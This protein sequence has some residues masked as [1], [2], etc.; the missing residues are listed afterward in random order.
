VSE[1]DVASGLVRRTDSIVARAILRCAAPMIAP[2]TRV[3]MTRHIILFKALVL[4]AL[5]FATRPAVPYSVQTHESLIDLAWKQSIRPFLLQ[6]FPALTEL[7]IQ[8]AH[9]YA[10]G[11]CNIQDFGYYP[12]A[13]DFFSDL[14]HY[15]RSGDFVLSLL[16]NAQTPDE[17]AFAI[18]ALSHY[19]G[20]SIGHDDAVNQSVA[21]EF[22][23][24]EKEYG[25]LVNYAQNP[26]AHVQVEFAF[27]INQLSK[28][29][30][31]PSDYLEHVGLKI[32][33]RVL[34]RAFFETYGLNLPGLIGTRDVALRTYRF[35]VRSFLPAIA[36]AE[37]ILHKFPPEIPS[38]AGDQ[39]TKALRQAEAENGWEQYR[40]NA[41]IGS[42]ALAGLIF[43]LPKVGTLALLKIRGPNPQTEDL[44]INSVNRSIA[45][46]R[47]VLANFGSISTYVPNR[48]LDTGK[49]VKPGGYKLTD[50]TYAKLLSELTKHPNRPI[51]R[52]LKQDLTE[53]YA[54]PLAP[55]T[56][57]EDS[58]KWAKVQANLRILQSMPTVGD[59]NAVATQF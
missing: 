22:P 20:D 32:P 8:E 26:H 35:A 36:R 24:L 45:A 37:T 33:A 15:V 40:K 13:N 2:S 58:K 42:H 49:K 51:P 21:I 27:D 19:I 10:Y 6:R 46:L 47:L 7:Q 11:G 30:F 28:Y 39:L 41:G 5:L 9:A 54:D 55:I 17:L 57:K 53:Y 3:H 43:I 34:R 29:H 59:P 4:L 56:T 31:A 44:Y 12:F 1:L 48:D 14:T 50:N 25:P 23:K 52:G 16:R 38:E 18:G